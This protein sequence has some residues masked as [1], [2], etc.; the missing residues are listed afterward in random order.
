MQS[1]TSKNWVL[2]TYMHVL[3]DL[4]NGDSNNKPKIIFPDQAII[5]SLSIHFAYR[6]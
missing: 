6:Q 3:I 5:F 1:G 2:C 4:K